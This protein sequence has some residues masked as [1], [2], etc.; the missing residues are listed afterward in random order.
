MHN[1]YFHFHLDLI[2]NLLHL[3]DVQ[4]DVLFQL[5]DLQI[6]GN[7][8]IYIYLFKTSLLIIIV[9]YFLL[10]YIYRWDPIFEPD[11]F[12][13]TYAEMP[14]ELKNTISHRYRSLDKLKTYLIDNSDALMKEMDK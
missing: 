6:L 5:E 13:Q 8:Y 12:N 2:K 14:K 11:G 1:V 7:I 3:M 10:N 9:V 4:K